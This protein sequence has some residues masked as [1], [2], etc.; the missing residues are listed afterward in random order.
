MSY[1]FIESENIMRERNGKEKLHKYIKGIYSML[2]DMCECMEEDYSD[3][4]H[5]RENDRFGMR[6]GGSR[7]RY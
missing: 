5:E 1:R 7:S 4:M 6:G 2:D 3:S